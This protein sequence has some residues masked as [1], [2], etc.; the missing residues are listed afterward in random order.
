MSAMAVGLFGFD[1]G[2][3]GGINGP[4]DFFEIANEVV[5]TGVEYLRVTPSKK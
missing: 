4:G 3:A 5:A 2:G 1:A